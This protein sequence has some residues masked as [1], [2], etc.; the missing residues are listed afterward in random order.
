MTTR[1]SPRKAYPSYEVMINAAI[2]NLRNRSGSSRAA[3]Y[4]WI[5]ATYPVPDK[6]L[7]TYLS[8]SLNRLVGQGKLIQVK[9][10]YK[11]SPSTKHKQTVR[12]KTKAPTTKTKAPTTK[13]KAPTTKTKAPTTKNKTPTTKIKTPITKA[14]SDLTPK[15]DTVEHNFTKTEPTINVMLSF[16]LNWKHDE[17]DPWFSVIVNNKLDYDH[18]KKLYDYI[19]KQFYGEDLTYVDTGHT[20]IYNVIKFNALIDM[21][22]KSKEVIYV[23]SDP[24]YFS[25]TG[26]PDTKD[27]DKGSYL[28]P[29]NYKMTVI[30]LSTIYKV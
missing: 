18:K 28:F 13:I 30:D 2:V 10:S 24:V 15:Q 23:N 16:G 4:K 20:Y 21:L 14:K 22:D 12:A 3:I 25:P 19:K 5:A 8:R 17:F 26:D 7:D 27:E 11:L 29:T 9:A 6:N 1:K